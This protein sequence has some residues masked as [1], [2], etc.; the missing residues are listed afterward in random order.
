MDRW[1]SQV[2]WSSLVRRHP[3]TFPLGSFTSLTT[4]R[5]AGLPITASPG[6]VVQT[7]SG[8]PEILNV[9]PASSNTASRSFLRLRAQVVR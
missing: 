2:I 7:G 9:G 4:I 1:K 6:I 3:S 5:T 8:N